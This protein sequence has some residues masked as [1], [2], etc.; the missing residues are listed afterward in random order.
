MPNRFKRKQFLFAVAGF[1]GAA[2]VVGATYFLTESP[3]RLRAD[4]ESA[5]MKAL[6]SL[7]RAEAEFRAQDL[8]H[9]GVKDFWTGDVAGLFR[10]VGSE[11]GD[12][13]GLPLIER[14]LAEADAAPIDRLAPRPVPYHGYY[15]VA[16]RDAGPET[17]QDLRSYQ[18]DTGGT[19]PMGKVHHLSKFAYCAYPAE[20]G[21][22]GNC[23]YVID[24]NSTIFRSFHPDTKVEA[25]KIWPI[26][27]NY[28]K[29]WCTLG[30]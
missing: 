17:D 15:F 14:A 26:D 23:T 16:F 11:H 19:P 1:A 22:T 28:R 5:A 25:T 24:E 12:R 18:Q 10:W 9:N 6:H 13:K 27:D 7:T 8:D 21:V 2:A 4:N 29:K 20:Y 3:S 30:D